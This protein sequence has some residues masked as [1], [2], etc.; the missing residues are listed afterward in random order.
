MDVNVVPARIGEQP[1]I[2]NLFQLYSHDFSEF[3]SGTPRGELSDAGRF[4]AIALAP[5]WQVGDH[6]PYLIRAGTHLAGFALV[7]KET[8]STAKA[9]FNMAEFFVV[10]KHR[11]RGTGRRAA[12]DIFARHRGTWEVAVA[13]RN[14]AAIAFWRSAIATLPGV[15]AFSQQDHQGARWN[16]PIF[17]FTSS[18]PVVA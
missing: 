15:G 18:A 13:R 11:G 17:R 9:D 5:Y 8:H 3:W 16:G 1:A 4:E 7:N 6:F 10:R 14:V 12:Q 2:E